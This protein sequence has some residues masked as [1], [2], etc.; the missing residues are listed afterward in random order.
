M[1]RLSIAD[2]RLLAV[3]WQYGKKKFA[4]L[5]RNGFTKHQIQRWKDV[6][7][8]A[9]D[10]DFEGW[11]DNASCQDGLKGWIEEN[12]YKSPGFASARR[13]Q[14]AGYPPNSPDCMLLDAAVFGRFK[15]LFAEACPKTIPEAVRVATKIVAELSSAPQKWVEHLDETYQEILDVNGAGTHYMD[16]VADVETD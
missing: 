12:G 14:P 13:K 6:P 3:H 16:D 2:R 5:K 11:I 10:A 15:V 7:F 9:P 4:W 8:T 1:G